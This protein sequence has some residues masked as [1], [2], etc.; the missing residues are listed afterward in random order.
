MENK[1]IHTDS[2]ERESIRLLLL[3]ASRVLVLLHCASYQ[4]PLVIDIQYMCVYID[5]IQCQY[6]HV[7]AGEEHGKAQD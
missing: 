7:N 1:V 3:E 5:L 4:R 2:G 6:L